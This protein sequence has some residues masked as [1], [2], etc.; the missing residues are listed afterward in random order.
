VEQIRK[1]SAE[2]AN[3]NYPV[4]LRVVVTYFDAISPDFFVQ[5]STGAIWVEWPRDA[6]SPEAGQLIELEGVTSQPNFAP[7]IHQPRW[8]VLGRGPMPAPRRPSFEQMA[9]TAKD[10]WWVE[11]EGIVHSVTL[12]TQFPIQYLSIAVAGGR[13]DV[14]IP[15]RAAPPP[16]LVDARVRLRGVC[17][18]R[19]N[20]GNQ[21]IGVVI[22]TPTLD[23]I[24]VVEP[25]AA[26]PF[27]A[28][29][30]PISQLH[31]FSFQGTSNR[32]VRVR[33]VVTAHA[34]GEAL[35]IQDESGSLYVES[36]HDT[37]LEV[38]SVTDVAGFPGVVNARPALLDAVCRRVAPG[39]APRPAVVTASEV[40]RG[41]YDS[42]LV[43]IEG[44]LMGSSALPHER[45]FLLSQGE[46]AFAAM[47]RE[48]SGDAMRLAVPEES[49]LRLS[50]ICLV[51]RYPTG[52]AK[53]F[54]IQ[55][56][57]PKDVVVV[58]KPSWI[59][60]DRAVMLLG[61][62]ATAVAGSLAWAS[63]LHRRLRSQTEVI[64]TTLESTADGI[65]V[66]DPAGKPVTTNEK[67]IQMW[68]IPRSALES[69]AD[70]GL[71]RYAVTQ[72][73]NPEAFLAT[74]NW[75][76]AHPNE[77]SHG[78]VEFNDG[79]VFE[80]HSEPQY[81]GE[82]N[83]GRVWGFRDITDRKQG[84]LALRAHTQQQVAVAE[85]GQFAL[86][87]PRL[88]QV[89]QMAVGMVA[90]TLGMEYCA[91]LETPRPGDSPTL[92]ASVGVGQD[93]AGGA[94]VETV[95]AQAR[96]A[97]AY[98]ETVTVE[99]FLTETRF[100]FPPDPPLASGVC[101]AI[102]AAGKPFAVLC[103]HS[104]APRAMSRDDLH[105]LQAIV[106]VLASA[107][108]RQQAEAALHQAKEAAESASRFKSEFVA[109]M[110]HE[111]RTPMNGILG[112]TE[113]LLESDLAPEQLESLGMVKSSA[114]SLLTVI[115]DILDFSKIEAG[116]LDFDAS[117]FNLREVLDGAL[118]GFALPASQKGL[119]LI[120]GVDPA[121]P[122]IVR[123]DAT[124]LRQVINNL[125]GNALKFTASGEVVVEVASLSRGPDLDSQ[126]SEPASQ[127]P[128]SRG[129]AA[130][131]QKSDSA[132]QEAG[133][134]SRDSAGAELRFVVS[135]TGIGIPREKQQLVFDS[136]SQADGSTARRY[137][138]TGLGLTIA[139]RLVEL[140]GGRIWVESQEGRGSQFYF[141][142]RFAA[143][144]DSAAAAEPQPPELAGLRVLIADDS[145]THRRILSKALS[146]WGAAVT[147]A[148]SGEAALAALRRAAGRAEPFGLLISDACM[149][150][151]DGFELAAQ[152]RRDPALGPTAILMLTCAA[153]GGAA[154]R[155]RELA[156]A[157]WLGKP[158][159]QAELGSAVLLALGRAPAAAQAP[160][161]NP[162]DPIAANDSGDARILLVDDN[163]INQ[164]LALHLL[165]KR[166]YRVALASNGIEAL[167][168][169]EKEPFDAVLMD[170]QMPRMDGFQATA[171]IRQHEKGGR[172]RVPIIAMTAHAMKGDEER[173]LAA[174]MDGYISKP[175]R[176]QTLFE[177]L[178]SHLPAAATPAR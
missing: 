19:F 102:H 143:P 114:E 59:N 111:I 14:Q 154:A 101:F 159:P 107:V 88:Q 130:A 15:N 132:W 36:L 17:G 55:L 129:S 162:R 28:P 73:Q 26:D 170:L 72:L 69:K 37:P 64:R 20:A 82:R 45:V 96:Y 84:E 78:I 112:M 148:E 97:L 157:A 166:G 30:Q 47:L 53:S 67:F 51:E 178:N 138:G 122:A 34:P 116:K 1:L 149:P 99:D 131:S 89:L 158:V 48:A 124:R 39:P 83:I 109:N 160:A 119:E 106:N 152:I 35:Y 49:V 108:E 13:M 144:R 54:R 110:S 16:G 24:E 133:P 33:G 50:G 92:R 10:G 76:F 121:A 62:L 9:S 98:S 172:P 165:Q 85:L 81:V 6:P 113:L 74:V 171:A 5:D 21:L 46:T 23:G 38:G 27:G 90:R 66:V 141:T 104:A 68:Q 94:I 169:L 79:K 168:A 177:V 4:R 163:L 135:D 153:G 145:A 56:R 52:E 100:Q 174:G 25:A 161:A 147:S 31:R 126:G 125:V 103:A 44:R 70:G 42:T 63:T 91:I 128:L 43:S 3:Q 60:L 77:Q 155:C 75:L 151:M 41:H 65:L 118:R 29:R 58:E 57:S 18:S 120:C 136:F 95:L 87:E 173:C 86:A 32:R 22:Y 61:L 115:N 139:T 11:V 137:G 140:M 7:D 164:K 134:A 123:G 2:Q 117:D 93:G 150:G 167:E 127:E 146:A 71:L 105:F 80:H 40:L 156:V 176:P 8:R 12:D 175:I 142:A